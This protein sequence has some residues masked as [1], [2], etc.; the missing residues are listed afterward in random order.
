MNESQYNTGIYVKYNLNGN[1]TFISDTQMFGNKIISIADSNFLTEGFPYPV[2]FGWVQEEDIALLIDL[3]SMI[4]SYSIEITYPEEYAITLDARHIQINPIDNTEF[5][6]S[7]YNV[8]Y[9]VNSQDNIET[10]RVISSLYESRYLI[11]E[12]SMGQ[13]WYLG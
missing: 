4:D 9:A 11:F 8:N 3:K 13:V 12:N 7:L 5:V 2:V 6:R 1:D 10:Y